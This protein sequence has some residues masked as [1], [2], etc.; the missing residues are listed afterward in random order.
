MV[1][2]IAAALTLLVACGGD[3]G[4]S[5]AGGGLRAGGLEDATATDPAKD[6]VL[7]MPFTRFDGREGTF[8]EYRGR[9]LVVNFFATWCPPCITEMPDFEAAHQQLGDRVAFVGANVRDQ[10]ADGQRLAAKT[11][12]TYDLVRDP[13]EELLQ[14]FGGVAMPT[15][16]FIDADGKIVRVESGRTYDTDELLQLI[17]E[18]F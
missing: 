15:T 14:A 4:G 18:L 3:D 5:R 11:G 12:V 1:P 7:T 6:T 10:L 16:A 2:T 13:R 17:D 8:A 9:P